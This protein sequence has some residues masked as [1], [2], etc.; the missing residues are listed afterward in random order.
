[1]SE[2]APAGTRPRTG[3]QTGQPTRPGPYLLVAAIVLALTVAAL[4]VAVPWLLGQARPAD[5]SAVDRH[6]DL[7]L[8]HVEGDVDYPTSPPVGGPHAAAWLGCGVYDVPVPAENAVHSLEHGAVWI[9]HEDLTGKDLDRLRE[10]LPDEGILSPHPDLPGPVVITVWGRQ[11]VL[12]GPEDPRLA[13]F[14]ERFGD[15]HTAPEPFA[16][17][18][19]GVDETGQV[20]DP[21]QAA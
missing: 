14:L 5:L 20:P 12:D 9:T 11:L 1:M 7:A 17:C 21:G 13:L 16:S 6:D 4:A 15:G 18:Q 8:D 2:P 10:Q 19:G 3:Q